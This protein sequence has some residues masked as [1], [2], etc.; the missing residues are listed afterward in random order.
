[1]TIASYGQSLKVEL[2]AIYPQKRESYESC[3]CFYSVMHEINDAV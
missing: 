1:M 2:L 3:F